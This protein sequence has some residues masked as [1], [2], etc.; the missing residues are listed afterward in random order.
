MDKVAAIRKRMAQAER[1]EVDRIK[2]QLKNH[3][4]HPLQEFE[5]QL[6]ARQLEA[7]EVPRHAGAPP[8][9][10]APH[11]SIAIDYWWLREN[12]KGRH[13]PKKVATR[14]GIS[15]KAV[16]K[17]AKA[18]EEEAL[19]YVHERQAKSKAD[20]ALYP[21]AVVD[22]MLELMAAQFRKLDE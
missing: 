9:L 8:L 22:Q 21:D 1:A 16:L 2:Q 19:K 11:R 14:W 18:H 20:S 17:Y 3:P 15:V 6:I 7:D 12:G 10:T 5:A 4:R 13:A